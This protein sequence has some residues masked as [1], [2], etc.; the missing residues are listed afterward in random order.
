MMFEKYRVVAQPFISA[1]TF[2]WLLFFLFHELFK[3]AFLFPHLLFESSAEVGNG[4]A[5]DP[6]SIR[7][8]TYID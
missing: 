1:L 5:Q 7:E 3:K 4:S 6:V 2:L 8:S